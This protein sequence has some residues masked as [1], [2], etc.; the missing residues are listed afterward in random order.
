MLNITFNEKMIFSCSIIPVNKS[1]STPTNLIKSRIS[2]FLLFSVEF[3]IFFSERCFLIKQTNGN[4]LKVITAKIKR[5]HLINECRM[6]NRSRTRKIIKTY[7]VFFINKIFFNM[8]INMSK[9]KCS[10]DERFSNS[11]PDDSNQ[12]YTIIA[13]KTLLDI[14]TTNMFKTY[15]CLFL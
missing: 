13:N 11:L 9:P 6:S 1:C 2:S 3:K 8:S 7:E 5:T 15:R 4:E 10:T 14:I 12:K